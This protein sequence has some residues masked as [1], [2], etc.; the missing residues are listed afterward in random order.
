MDTWS[1]WGIAARAAACRVS[2]GG[3]LG[4]SQMPW[5]C[6]HTTTG[7]WHSCE[8]VRRV[9]PSPHVARKDSKGQRG[10]GEGDPDLCVRIVC[11]CANASVSGD[12][13]SNLTLGE[14]FR[15]GQAHQLAAR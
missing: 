4:I 7:P 1:L 14:R 6:L 11:V 5:G 13:L 10:H 3:V 15:R 2:V 8:D 9:L 12:N